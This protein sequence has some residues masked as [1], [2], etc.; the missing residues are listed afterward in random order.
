MR[1]FVLECWIFVC[2]CPLSSAANGARVSPWR[3]V[4]Y[5]ASWSLYERNFELSHV[6]GDRLTHLVYAFAKISPAGECIAGDPWADTGR[7]N[8]DGHPS[9]RSGGNFG[10]LH[11]LRRKYPN[12]KVL[13]AIGG[14]TWSAMFS[15]VA[16]TPASRNAF[17]ASCAR[18][19]RRHG[20]DG[21]DVDWEYPVAGGLEPGRPEDKH[22]YTLLLS[23]LR[24]QL[25]AQ[26]QDHAERRYLLTAAV[27]AGPD[28]IG[29]IEPGEF[30]PY[31]DWINIMAYDF[32][33]AWSPLTGFV[34]PLFAP[35]TAET[36]RSPPSAAA[37]VE[38][39][40][41]TGVPPEKVVLGLPF[42]GRG[43]E[44]VP[45]DHEGLFQPHTGAAEGSGKHGVFGFRHLMR[46][47]VPT[48]KRHWH[49]AAKAAWLYD[50][51]ARLMISYEDT[52]SVSA[53]VD[54]VKGRKLGGI[55]A[56]EL[57]QDTEGEMSL[58]E[59]I[60]EELRGD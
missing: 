25:D 56:W 12:L 42:Y 14:W 3:V 53:K 59:T 41:A 26:A 5:Y 7:P 35:A 54:Y 55:M 32:S 50:P 52:E 27:P 38:A 51:Q 47:Y 8:P 33:G 30:H 29:N 49:D 18:F 17:A 2:L 58:L 19:M 34:A 37:A 10:Q 43:W 1:L 39:Y 22:N 16:R 48:M 44:G 11:E 24:R 40:L 6:P 23:A 31:L 20:F 21:L 15:D 36:E 45:A 60:W 4:G 57:S 28:K 9:P 46:D 13:L